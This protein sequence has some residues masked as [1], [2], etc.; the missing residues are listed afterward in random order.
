MVEIMDLAQEIYEADILR[1]AQAVD[2]AWTADA[3]S[4]YT[5]DQLNEQLDAL[6]AVIEG[7]G[8]YSDVI[9]TI[10][11]GNQSSQFRLN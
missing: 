1:S 11:L 10:Q 2:A 9:S 6:I 3:R 4:K 8:E 5:V 7:N